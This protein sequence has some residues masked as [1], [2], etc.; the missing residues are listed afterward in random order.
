MK[1][2]WYVV[3]ILAAGGAATA[4]GHVLWP[5]PWSAHDGV[6]TAVTAILVALALAFPLKVSPQAEASLAAAPL[7][8][9]VLLLSPLQA[10]VA[11]AAGTVIADIRLRRR[12]LAAAFNMGVTS[13]AVALASTLY[14]G[15][16]HPTPTPL[17]SLSSLG[18]A[19]LVGGVLHATNLGAM[20]GMVS[21]HKGL[22]FWGVWKR[23]WVM[24]SVQ[25]AGSL[26]LG[27]LAAALA[28]EVWWAAFLLVVPLALVYLALSRSVKEAGENIQLAQ[29][30]K[31]QMEELRTTQAQLIQSAKM[32][33]IGTLAAGVAHEI[34]NPLFVILGRAEML[35]RNPELHLAT[36]RAREG[37]TA[38]YDMAQRASKIVQELLAFSRTSNIPE[39]VQLNE[40]MDVALNLAGKEI[41]AHRIKIIKEYAEVP[42]IQG[43]PNRLQQVF[44][45]L[46]LNA[47]DAMPQGGTILLRCWAQDGYVNAA[48]KDTG[49]GIPQ[50]LQP[51]LFEPFFTTKEVGKGTGVGLFLCHRIVTEHQGHIRI[52]SEEGVGTEVVV[53]L[54]LGEQGP[55][56]SDASDS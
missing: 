24:D 1:Y 4:L 26:A 37:L 31:E 42:P 33:S 38:I 41:A 10:V 35:L 23:A 30:L 34:N 45:N 49:R 16:S 54:P 17:L 46:L 47:R 25:E 13:L 12:P 27:Y 9:G 50:E 39:Q 6:L 7:F 18:F 53:E 51:H 32:A 52:E 22:S 48:V 40:V 5:S 20:V 29:R 55:T 15:L 11:A 43:H 2:R 8:L 14:H 28:Q 21:L 3:G 36:E 56:L 19:A 44:I